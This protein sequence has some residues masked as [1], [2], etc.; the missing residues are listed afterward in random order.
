MR[1]P[2]NCPE[3]A[4]TAKRTAKANNTHPP[5]DSLS[6][7]AAHPIKQGKGPVIAP[8]NTAIEF[9]FFNGV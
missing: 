3:N 9:T 7:P 8:I 6:S 1:H 4:E 5:V 2:C